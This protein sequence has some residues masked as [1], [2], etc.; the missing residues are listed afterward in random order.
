MESFARMGWRVWLKAAAWWKVVVMV[1]SKLKRS[2]K[3][4]PKPQGLRKC[5]V[6]GRGLSHRWR[7]TLWVVE[8]EESS[9]AI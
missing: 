6:E 3:K 9:R 8:W 2:K 7:E 4:D 5:V 1:Y